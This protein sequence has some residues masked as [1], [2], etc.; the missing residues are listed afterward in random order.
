LQGDDQ[1]HHQPGKQ[2]ACNPAD[3]QCH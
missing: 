2:A 1:G 3:N